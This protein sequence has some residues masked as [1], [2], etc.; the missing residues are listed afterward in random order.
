MSKTPRTDP[1]PYVISRM[2]E[3][4]DWASL[5]A[6]KRDKRIAELEQQLAA[7]KK[8]AEVWKERAE[9][10]YGLRTYPS[11]PGLAVGALDATIKSGWRWADKEEAIDAAIGKAKEGK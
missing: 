1:L 2:S 6:E 11:N 10:E 5:A 9:Y 4:E 7:A 8:D 3:W